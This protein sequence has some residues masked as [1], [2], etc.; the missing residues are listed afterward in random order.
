MQLAES[1]EPRSPWMAGRWVQGDENGDES[2]CLSLAHSD[3]KVFWRTKAESSSQCSTF[4][5]HK[6][7]G[8]HTHKPGHTATKR[9][10]GRSFIYILLLNK[11]PWSYCT[12]FISTWYS[13]EEKM[14]VFCHLFFF[15]FLN[16]NFLH[17]WKT[18]L[19]CWCNVMRA[20]KH[21]KWQA[22]VSRVHT[23]V[24]ILTN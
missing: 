19:S 21:K 5:I 10:S 20:G 6:A 16:K 4:H 24:Y 9:C 23:Q 17:L 7:L 1:A 11:G 15:F 18:I 12:R 8:A 13:K 2:A 3:I 14:L 22:Q